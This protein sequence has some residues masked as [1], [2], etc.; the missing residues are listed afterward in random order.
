MAYQSRETPN[1]GL[2]IHSKRIKSKRWVYHLLEVMGPKFPN[3][4]YKHGGTLV[5]GGVTRVELPMSN[6][7]S[8]QGRPDPRGGLLCFG[9]QTKLEPLLLVHL[10]MIGL[11][12]KKLCPLPSPSKEVKNS[13]K[14]T[15]EHYK[16]DS[17]SPEKFLVCCSVVIRVQR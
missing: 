11:E 9:V 16:A 14:R 2:R 8:A 3:R 13:K 7:L 5:C 12:L 1:L 17:Q 15:T 4:L 10:A 6:H